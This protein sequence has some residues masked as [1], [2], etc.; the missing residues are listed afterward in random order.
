MNVSSLSLEMR[1]APH[2]GGSAAGRADL[3]KGGLEG[4]DVGDV[5]EGQCSRCEEVGGCQLGL[6]R[7]QGLDQSALVLRHCLQSQVPV[8][9]KAA[10]RT[11]DGAARVWGSLLQQR[12]GNV[13]E[14]RGQAM[15]QRERTT[16]GTEI[17]W[18]EDVLFRHDM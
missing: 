15:S 14:V 13:A 11:G 4:C 6:Q 1:R 3:V 7:H 5:C 18:N 12:E 2:H 9:G 10:G 8:C 16:P 17:R